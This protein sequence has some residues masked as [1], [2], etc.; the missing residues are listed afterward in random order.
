MHAGSGWINGKIITSPHSENPVRL[1]CG[2]K[3]SLASYTRQM[4][5]K[6]GKNIFESAS[7][8]PGSDEL[9]ESLYDGNIRIEKIVSNGQTTPAGEWYEQEKDEF[10]ML[11]QG[12]A[13]ILFK[14]GSEVSL[15]KGDHLLIPARECHRVTF[16][17]ANPCC[18]WLAIH[19]DL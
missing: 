12:E 13:R 3:H 11:L 9:F 14:T 6:T 10:V 19:G 2:L 8:T 18:I 16:T 17:S 15:V 5:K 1:K 4:D 7:L